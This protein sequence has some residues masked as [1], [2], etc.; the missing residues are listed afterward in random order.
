MANRI[1]KMQNEN[2]V[3]RAIKTLHVDLG[4]ASYPIWIGEGLL[5]QLGEK[6]GEVYGGKKIFILT[7]HHV[8]A[9]YGD[10]TEKI[11][12]AAGFETKRLALEPGEATKSFAT[13]PFIY[14][15]LID[16]QCTRK[17][18]L[19]TLGGGVIGDLGGFAAATFLRGI[20]FVS[21]PTSLLAQVDSSVGGKVGVDLTQG[22]NL[23]GSFY[24]PKAVLI[25][26]LLLATLSERYFKDG[27]A[28][29]IKYACIGNAGLFDKLVKLKSREAVMREV[30]K[31]IFT[32]CHMKKNIVEADEKDLDRRMLLNFGHT[33]GHAV[34]SFEHYEGHSHGEAVAIGMHTITQISEAAGVTKPGTAKAL[35]QVLQEYGLPYEI[36]P[37]RIIDLL[38]AIRIDKKNLGDTLKIILI[39]E[40]GKGIIENDGMAYFE[41]NI[42]WF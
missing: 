12:Q 23:V 20:P 7:D 2:T 42:I 21:V 11:L 29:V 4:S 9:L 22:K 17:D 6:L 39:K 31:I 3:R 26:P 38:P 27:M 24:Q 16:F 15:A 34:E 37:Y 35:R 25:D 13:L 41:N 10:K 40:L 28:E 33:I 32:C 1:S 36:E 14:Q 19:I 8:N 30:T 5:D 18:L